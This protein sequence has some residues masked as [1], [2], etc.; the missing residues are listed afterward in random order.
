[1]VTVSSGVAG[2]DVAGMEG[3]GAAGRRVVKKSAMV[4]ELLLRA[5]HPLPQQLPARR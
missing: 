3:V 5:V 4:G 2:I 1:M